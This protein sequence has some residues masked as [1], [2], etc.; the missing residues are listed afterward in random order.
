MSTS[1]AA[2]VRRAGIA[3]IAGALITAIGGVVSQFVQASTTV[4]D[5]LWRY[6][7]SSDAFVPVSVLWAAAHVL[8]IIGLLG[9]R[10]SALAGDS[11]AAR[12]GITLA[13]AGTALLLV[14]EI[15]SLPMTDEATNSTAGGIVGAVFGLGTLL[16]AVGLLLAGK[17]TL[18]ARRWQDWRRFTPITA[19][20]WTLAL[21]GIA[22]TKGMPTGV[23]IYGLCLLALGIALYSR[24]A[25]ATSGIGRTHS[26]AVSNA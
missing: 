15:A 8:V 5:D 10:R 1:H 17:A 26:Q 25:V 9:F 21:V 19:G 6:P 4:S 3:L 23:A 24:P 20:A 13:I 2:T 16:S 11:A 12:R 18:S 22:M 7:W 14:G